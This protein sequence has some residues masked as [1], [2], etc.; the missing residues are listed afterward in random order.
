MGAGSSAKLELDSRRFL[1]G[2][3]DCLVSELMGDE[4]F[5]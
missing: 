3:A 2:A 4:E 1:F 5:H